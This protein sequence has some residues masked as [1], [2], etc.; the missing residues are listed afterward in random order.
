M[1]I[2]EA[3]EAVQ[4][5]KPSNNETLSDTAAATDKPKAT[6]R[7]AKSKEGLNTQQAFELAQSRGYLGNAK[8]FRD[9]FDKSG[10]G[11]QFGLKR[12]PHKQGRE[13]WLYF[14]TQTQS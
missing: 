9:R 5:D 13:N 10:Y 8:S 7:S 12:I 4:S 11:D 6:R 14:D 1:P 2:I 3:I